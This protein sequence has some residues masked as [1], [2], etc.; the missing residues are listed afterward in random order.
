MYGGT[1]RSCP[2]GPALRLPERKVLVN[3]STWIPSVISLTAVLATFGG[4]VY[5]NR[6]NA[7]L[8]NSKMSS[9]DRTRNRDMLRSKGEELFVL[10]DSFS[11]SF[12]KV[13]SSIGEQFSRGKKPQDF[14]N[15]DPTSSMAQ[16]V[17]IELLTRV[18]F[19]GGDAELQ[20]LLEAAN[21]YHEIFFVIV[22]ESEPT[23]RMMVPDKLADM[24]AEVDEHAKALQAVV[25]A[26]L[27][28]LHEEILNGFLDEGR[29]NT[30]AG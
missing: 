11:R 5:T 4:I 22:D 21:R 16:L 29:E 25:V 1:C 14:E 12:G 27:S 3:A 8:Q 20:S 26:R 17:R 2:P 13:M 18:Y 15:A 24:A 23:E 9:E 7:R 10:L 19:P 6:I 28:S 30:I